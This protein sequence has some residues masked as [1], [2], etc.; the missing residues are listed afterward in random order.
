MTR[1]EQQ[2]D[3]NWQGFSGEVAVATVT[4]DDEEAPRRASVS[5]PLPDRDAAG[6]SPGYP[7]YGYPAYYAAP[8]Y[9]VA[10]FQL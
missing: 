5:R 1:W 3:G 8:A 9:C 2:P 4:R 6:R 10:F 7:A